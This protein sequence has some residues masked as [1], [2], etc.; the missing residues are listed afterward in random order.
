MNASYNFRALS[1]KDFE[2]L[3]ADLI[4]AECSCHV[5]TYK[6]G[7]DGGVDLRART[8]E[9]VRIIGQAKHY[10]GSSFNDLKKACR[11]EADRV[12]KIS[13]IADRYILGTTQALSS[14]QKYELVSIFNG[15][16]LSEADILGADDIA[17]LLRR[18]K[19]VERALSLIHI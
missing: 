1:P 15:F 10:I 12:G 17:S 7:P 2:D 16:P 9:G 18:H 14:S 8:S 4:A 13:K 11:P 3:L 19:S 5:E 6:A